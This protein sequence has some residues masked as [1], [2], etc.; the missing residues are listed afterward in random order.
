MEMGRSRFELFFCSQGCHEA[1]FF[2]APRDATQHPSSIWPTKPICKVAAPEA[3]AEVLKMAGVGGLEEPA[4]P[5]NFKLNLRLHRTGHV[6]HFPRT[7]CTCCAA[8]GATA[9]WTL[10]R[11]SCQWGA[12][13]VVRQLSSL[14]STTATTPIS[15]WQDVPPLK[16]VLKE[17]LPISVIKLQSS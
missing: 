9:S 16:V 2:C 1:F 17:P 15:R 11:R 10:G 6:E 8:Y 5:L 4:G 3:Q 13:P 7:Q 14:H 12:D